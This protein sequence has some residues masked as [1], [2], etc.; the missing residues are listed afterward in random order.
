LA[1]PTPLRV[2]FAAPAYWP[3]LAFGGAIWV[4][5]ELCEGLAARGHSVDVVT[6]S[7]EDLR[8]GTTLRARTD[9]IGGVRVHYLATPV[10]YRWMGVTPGLPLALARLGGF[11]VA[12]VLGFRDPVGTGVAAWCLARRVPY[13]L[14]PI[15]MFRPRLRKMLLKRVLDPLLA[16]LVRRAALVVATSELERRDLTAAGLDDARI[17]VRP[18]PFPPVR[19]GRSGALRARLGLD[20]EPLVL[21][22]GRLGA[23]KGIELLVD[24]VERLPGVHLALVGPRDALDVRVRSDRVHLVP[25]ADGRPL[26][27][28]GDAD[29]FVLASDSERENF[30]LA[31]AEAAAAGV[32]LVVTERTGIAE[33]VGGR[34]AL[35]VPPDAAAISEAIARVLGDGALRAR[36]GEGGRELAEELSAA[37]VVERQ[38]ELYRRISRS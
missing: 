1:V 4:A 29:V 5:K 22:T 13:V 8:R 12:H 19:E 31:A 11:D 3:A 6:T 7:L 14:E 24:A 33:L 28:Y 20:G 38:E 23:G 35:V 26:E 10:R 15:G 16:P 30:G 2:L 21:Y 34:A 27:L 36:L 9:E 37:A 32:P 18:N 25:P 17:A